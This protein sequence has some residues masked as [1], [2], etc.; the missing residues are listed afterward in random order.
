MK[1]KINA[2]KIESIYSKTYKILKM[3]K[4]A[5]LIKIVEKVK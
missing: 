4:L 1:R 5:N 2:R 3:N